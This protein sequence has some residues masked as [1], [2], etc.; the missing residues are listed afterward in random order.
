MSF[1]LLQ[2]TLGALGSLLQANYRVFWAGADG[3][4]ETDLQQNIILSFDC[5]G[6]S[7]CP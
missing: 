3:F 6:V 5:H 7:S 4:L 1:F 2:G